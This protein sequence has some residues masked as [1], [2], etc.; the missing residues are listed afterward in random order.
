MA[1]FLPANNC[2]TL[3]E[4][5]LVD[6]MYVVAK[7][8]SIIAWRGEIDKRFGWIFGRF[9]K[10]YRGWVLREFGWELVLAGD[11][12]DRIAII[13]IMTNLWAYIA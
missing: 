13:F 11:T 7:Y 5:I 2:M 1:P 6:R 9:L 4:R 10:V 8:T 3:L 12:A